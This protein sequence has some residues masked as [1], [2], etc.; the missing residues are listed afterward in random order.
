MNNQEGEKVL[1]GE[2]L[3]PGFVE[4][5]NA[6]KTSIESMGPPDRVEYLSVSIGVSALKVCAS[7]HELEN[8]RRNKIQ[9]RMYCKLKSK[10]IKKGAIAPLISC[11]K[12]L[13]FVDSN[14]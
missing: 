6:L 4:L 12:L 10:G 5:M 7:L 11:Q 1:L 9:L 8:T 2:R 3:P 14:L 13:Q